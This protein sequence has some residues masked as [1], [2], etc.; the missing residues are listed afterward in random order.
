MT[1]QVAGFLVLLSHQFQTQVFGDVAP[2][3]DFFDAVLKPNRKQE[4]KDST[5]HNDDETSD[6]SAQKPCVPYI[7]VILDHWV[8]IVPVGVMQ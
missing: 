2:A 1:L 6:I 5:D 8:S 4:M 7:I 3:V